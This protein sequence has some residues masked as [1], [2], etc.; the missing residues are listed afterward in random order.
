MKNE[1]I[2]TGG[3]NITGGQFAVNVRGDVEQHASSAP[4]PDVLD[5][6]EALLA[7]HSARLPEGEEAEGDLADVREQLTKDTPDR[8]RITDALR[9]LS[10]RVASVAALITAVKEV[11]KS[12]GISL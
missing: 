12:L 8:R 3:G 4:P 5:R 9:R 7:E 2:S 6:L 1:G 11:A 10:E